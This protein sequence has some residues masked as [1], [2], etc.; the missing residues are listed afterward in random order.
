MIH[1]HTHLKIVSPEIGLG[2]FATKDIP[3]GT[4][5]YAKDPLEI[6]IDKDQFE[7]LPELVKQKADIYSY[8][9]SNG[10][11]VLSWDSAKFVNHCCEANTLSTGY[12]FEIAIRDIKAGEEITDDY[13]MFNIPQD[14]KLYCNC[15]GCR[16]VLRAAD[17]NQLVPYWDEK[18]ITA[19]ASLRKVEQ[20]LIDLIPTELRDDLFDYL[21]TGKNYISV[22]QLQLNDSDDT[23]VTKAPKSNS[24]TSIQSLKS[25]RLKRVAASGS[26]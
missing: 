18:V 10:A 19:L 25:N 7:S 14:M 21:D 5:V 1:P 3:L 12:G 16:E 6:V 2:V 11:R 8:I 20:P 24:A 23:L 15:N 13:G 17:F 26:R 4:I 9:E 22:A